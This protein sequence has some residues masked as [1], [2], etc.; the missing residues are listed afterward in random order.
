MPVWLGHFVMLT[1]GMQSKHSG[2][3]R[4]HAIHGLLGLLRCR[5]STLSKQLRNDFYIFD[6]LMNYQRIWPVICQLMFRWVPVKFVALQL[7]FLNVNF[8]CILKSGVLFQEFKI[9]GS[10]V[11]QI[12]I[13]EPHIQT[14][15]SQLN[16]RFLTVALPLWFTNRKGKSCWRVKNSLLQ[17]I[18]L[19]WCKFVSN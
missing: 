18:N 6:W 1:W 4:T 19:W 11:Y 10:A 15:L 3:T 8:F 2:V 17:L 16:P 5:V 12:M 14:V 13:S 9:A 7:S